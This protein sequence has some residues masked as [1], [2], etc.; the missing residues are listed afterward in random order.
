M[1]ILAD[2]HHA[3]LAE[4]LDLLADRHGWQVFFP[5][6]MEWFE[7]DYWE[8]EKRALGD[9]VARQYLAGVWPDPVL[10][11]DHYEQADATHPGRIRKGVTLEQASAPRWDVV[12]CTLT[13]NER[14][15]SRFAAEWGA[16][17]GVQAGNVGQ[18]RNV[19]AEGAG[20]ER[21]RFALCSTT[22]TE[23]VPVPHV[24]YRQEFSLADFRPEWPSE[25]ASVASFIQCFA[26]NKGFYEQFL[27]IAREMPD[28]DWKVYGAYGS[29]EPDEFAQG[30]LSTTPAVAEAMRRTRIAWHAKWWSDGYG[31]VIHNLFATGRPIVGPLGYYLGEGG[32]PRQLA[33][34]LMEHGVTCFD[35][36]Q[37]S[38]PE[39]QSTLR[40]LRD[41][42][43]FWR[44]ISDNAASRFAQVV[45]FDADAER[46]KALLESVV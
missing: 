18:L 46:V 24:V 30:N 32:Y 8:F 5:M 37:M 12:L 44:E 39:V 33:A 27:V 40:R 21:T 31:H 4:S 45:D 38:Y 43:E 20:W 42:D 36:G 14:G 29:A 2:Y 26:E 11:G 35:T 15:F 7:R 16:T 1:K 22:L 17:Y 9:A 41:D 19:A 10:A 28:L 23:P 6:G 34:D 13:H 3:D 25:P